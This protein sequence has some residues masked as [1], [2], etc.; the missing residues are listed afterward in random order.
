MKRKIVLHG[1]STLTVSLPLGW[2]KKFGLKKGDEL[3][4]EDKGNEL[5]V[6]AENDFGLEKKELD[7]KSFERLGKTFVTSSYRQGYDELKLHYDKKDYF[8]IVQ[9]LASRETTG[10]EIVE[11][12]K[13]YCVIKDLTGYSKDEFDMAL[14]RMW[15]LLLDLAEEGLGFL[16]TKDGSVKNIELIDTRINK[17]SNYCLRLL[18]K[19]SHFDFRKSPIYYHFVRSLEEIADQYKDLCVHLSNNFDAADKNLVQNFSK[20]NEHLN[21][22]YELF[23]KYDEQKVEDFFARTKATHNKLFSSNLG[24][25]CS[26]A[27]ICR[28]IRGLISV[29]VEIHI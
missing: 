3:N 15:L 1:S 13:N 29:L 20:L 16:K 10:F 24:C 12:G 25:A 27:S 8:G 21:E 11:Q 14:R 26:L 23:Y 6:S 7:S 18:T 2:A 28:N 9:E 5:R 17:L 4:I 22:L 19:K